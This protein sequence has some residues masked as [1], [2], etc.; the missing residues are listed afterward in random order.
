MGRVGFLVLAVCGFLFIGGHSS[1]AN[2]PNAYLPVP[3]SRGSGQAVRATRTVAPGESFWTI[4]EDIVARDLR[5]VAPYWRDLI[6]ANAD[7]I[8][9]GDPDLIYPGEIL[10]LPSDSRVRADLSDSR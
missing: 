10:L 3:M 7:R 1:T 4:S 8:R 9:S 5:D 2:E 6:A